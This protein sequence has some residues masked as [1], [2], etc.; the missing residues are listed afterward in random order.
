M[1]GNIMSNWQDRSV[2][3]TSKGTIRCYKERVVQTILDCLYNK[4]IK[5]PDQDE[6]WIITE[7]IR[8]KYGLPNCVGVA[9]GTLLPLAF[10]PSTDDYAN[11][12]GKIMLF[13]VTMS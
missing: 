7:R 6:Q 10:W 1:E 12:K 8:A 2:F 5:W 3:R 13:T 11:Y 9:D 4:F